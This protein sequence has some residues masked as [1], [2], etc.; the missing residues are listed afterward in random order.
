M[1]GL[2]VTTVKRIPN[3][4]AKSELVRC[5]TLDIEEGQVILPVRLE[6]DWVKDDF[7]NL[8]EH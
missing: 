1:T 3:F 2:L 6:L 8:T 4:P 5:D 7:E